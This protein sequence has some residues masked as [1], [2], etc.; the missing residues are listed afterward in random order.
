MNKIRIVR[1]LGFVFI[2]ANFFLLNVFIHEAG[3]YIAADYYN[4]E[5]EIEFDFGAVGDLGFGFEGTPIA[6]TS[7]NEP[8]NNSGLM[9]IVLTGPL[10]NLILSLLFFNGFIFYRNN[11]YIKEIVIIGFILSFA[12]FIMNLIPIEGSDGSLI[13]ELLF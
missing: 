2:F 9:V 7:F 11:K 3:H 8:E 13:F 12:S 4:L 10:F 6:S 1:L 5:P